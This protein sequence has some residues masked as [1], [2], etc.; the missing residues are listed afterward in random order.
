MLSG[1]AQPSDS[2]RPM[3]PASTADCAFMVHSGLEG[4]MVETQHGTIP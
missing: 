3:S 4:K 1:L 2:L